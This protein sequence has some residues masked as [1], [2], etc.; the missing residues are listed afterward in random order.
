MTIKLYDLPLSANSRKVRAV[1]LE[2]GI[3]AEIE[4][5]N[6][7]EGKHK[8]P[9]FLKLNPNGKLP[10]IVDD[11]FALWES[12]AILTYLAAKSGKL[13]PSDPKGRASVAQWLFWQSSHFG[14]A[15]GK[16]GFERIL[17]PMFGA[18]QPDE[19]V[20][21]AGVRDF[22]TCSNVLDQSL[23]DGREYLAGELSIAD[24]AIAPWAEFGIQAGLSFDKY[25]QVK[26]WYERVAARD[27]FKQSAAKR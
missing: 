18:G 8:T 12:N 27:S 6:V 24:F 10:T 22:D 2:L 3:E 25:P 1:L 13:L 15:V 7:R 19:A 9:E 17:K 14:P 21:A 23:S 5:V 11:G 16:V 20:V 26:A 4:T